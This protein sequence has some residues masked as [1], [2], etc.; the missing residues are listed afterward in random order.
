MDPQNDLS[1]LVPS[2]ATCISSVT[3]QFKRRSIRREVAIRNSLLSKRQSM[4]CLHGVKSASTHISKQYIEVGKSYY[5]SRLDGCIQE[6][7]RKEE[8]TF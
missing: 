3:K 4:H 5:N 2:S 7:I 1:G 6:G 8:K